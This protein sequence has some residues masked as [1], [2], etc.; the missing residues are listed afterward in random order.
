MN[1]TYTLIE[2]CIDKG[3]IERLEPNFL[4]HALIPKKAV[5]RAETDELIAKVYDRSEIGLLAALLC[6]ETLTAEQIERMR[7]LVRDWE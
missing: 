6:R 5:Q 2:R 4:C 1:T 7:Q 3:A